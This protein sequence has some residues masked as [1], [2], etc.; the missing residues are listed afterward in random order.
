MI[1]RT[2]IDKALRDAVDSGGV[3]H[4]AAIAADRHGVIYLGAVGPRAVGENDPVAMDTL[5]RITSMTKM[6][7]TVA[8]LQQVEQ[9][10]LDLGTPVA[11]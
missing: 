9:G 5:F 7:C 3:P 8:A 11:D 1:G 10:N 2:A 6:P 4:V